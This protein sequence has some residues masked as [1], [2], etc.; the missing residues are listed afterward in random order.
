ML[1]PVPEIFPP[2]QSQRARTA[3]IPLAQPQRKGGSGQMTSPLSRWTE[4]SRLRRTVRLGVGMEVNALWIGWASVGSGD[5]NARI[6]KQRRSGRRE[7]AWRSVPHGSWRA[8]TR[9][10]PSEAKRP[11]VRRAGRETGPSTFRRPG[12]RP[13]PPPRSRRR[14]D[15][16]PRP[17]RAFDSV[18]GR[19]SSARRP[20]AAAASPA[21]AAAGVRSARAPGGRGAPRCPWPAGQ[22]GPRGSPALPCTPR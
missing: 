22:A 9:T 3:P 19:A 1:G 2:Q 20:R 14:R 6:V 21:G 15:H 4:T 12:R 11:Y 18:L 5:S 8:A 16:G 10:S 7:A 17:F 13:V